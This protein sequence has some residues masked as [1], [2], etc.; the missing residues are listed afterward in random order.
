MLERLKVHGFRT[1]VNAEIKLTP[2]TIMIGKNGAG[3]TTILDVLQL[4][5]KFARG[6]PERA[7]GPPPWSLGWQRTKGVG[8]IQ[9]VDI[10][11][12][13]TADGKSY[14]YHLRLDERSRGGDAFVREERLMRIS[15]NTTVAAFDTKR[16][17][18][19]G[20][21]LNP[22]PGWTNSE[23]LHELRSV[24]SHLQAF[25]SYELNPSL[26]ERGNDPKITFVSRDGFGV[27]GFLAN[28]K[29]NDPDKFEHL[30]NKFRQFRPETESI[31]IWS[32]GDVFHWSLRDFGQTHDFPAVHI[33]WGDRQILG[34][35]C[36]LYSARAG[37]TIAFEEVDRGFHSGRYAAVLDLLSE[38]VYDGLEGCN[39]LQIVATTHSP[40]F[41]NKLA[42]RK[43]EVRMVSRAPRGSTQ[44]RPLKSIVQDALGSE[45][46]TQ[47]LGEVWEMGLLDDVTS[48]E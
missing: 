20:T 48:P 18:E 15:D 32:T 40:S 30:Q 28:L 41:L 12:D 25:E 21:I 16:P 3:K 19:S 31:K 1:L 17:P 33:S 47:P 39:K 36:V 26:I 44:V 4:I 5:G 43:D 13:I 23:N 14:R 22:S 6:G 29:D 10:E 9:T 37:A 7:F 8:F 35:L 24:S 27:A 45:D 46:T 34:L 38:A 42:E 2:L 11:L